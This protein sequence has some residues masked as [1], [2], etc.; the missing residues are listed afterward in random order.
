MMTMTVMT[1]IGKASPVEVFLAEIPV[2]KDAQVLAVGEGNLGAPR[3]R[4]DAPAHHVE[5]Q[6]EM[7]VLCVVWPKA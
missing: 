1:Y 7:E 4:E 6:L 5:G 2:D 3:Y